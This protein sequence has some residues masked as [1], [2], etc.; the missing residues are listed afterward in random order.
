[1]ATTQIDDRAQARE[2]KA[3]TD[4]AIAAALA[5]D[6]GKA[7]EANRA[8]LQIAPNNIEALNRLTKALLERGELAEARDAVDGALKLD[9]SNTIARRN[10]DRLERAEATAETTTSA[11]APAGQGKVAEAV[12][13]YATGGAAQSDAPNRNVFSAHLLMSETGKS[14]I[15]TLID[16][17]DRTAV[18]HLSSGEA[19]TLSR[20]DN[21][22]LVHSSRGEPVG[23]VHPRLAQRIFSLMDAGNRYEAAFLRDHP[24]QGV[25]A[26]IGEVYQHPSQEGRPSFPPSGASD[27]RGYVRNNHDLVDSG[28]GGPPARDISD[29]EAEPPALDALV[30]AH[31]RGELGR[32]NG[33]SKDD[34]G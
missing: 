34:L 12:A 14:T 16:A 26:I 28:L 20:E 22:L 29:D 4:A 6:W 30:R 13:E 25:Q 1:M 9:S 17:T 23:R 31:D 5:Q 19:L 21:R 11:P 24:A 2:V 33:A 7:V 3:Q 8:V 10:R 32:S 27:F 18:G 15:A